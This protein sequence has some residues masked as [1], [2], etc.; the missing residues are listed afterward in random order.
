MIIS[1]IR[2][3]TTTIGTGRKSIRGCGHRGDDDDVDDN[4]VVVLSFISSFYD[5]L[6]G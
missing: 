1:R 6:I 5:E 2:R 3:S 4:V